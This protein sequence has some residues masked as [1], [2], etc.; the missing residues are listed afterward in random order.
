LEKTSF[1]N[2]FPWSKRGRRFLVEENSHLQKIHE[3]CVK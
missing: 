2:F 1:G 3:E